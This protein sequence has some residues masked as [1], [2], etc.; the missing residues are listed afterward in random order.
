MKKVAL[1]AVLTFISIA[2]FAK[3]A[4]VILE[5]SAELYIAQEHKIFDTQKDKIKEG[6][7]LVV[8]YLCQDVTVYYS[9]GSSGPGVYCINMSDCNAHPADCDE[10]NV[11]IIP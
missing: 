7:L 2:S 3:G 8:S 6:S 4:N 10:P 9:D 5:K 11:L 1:I